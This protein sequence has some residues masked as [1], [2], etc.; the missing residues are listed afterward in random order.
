MEIP[1]R[2]YSWAVGSARRAQ[3]A[4]LVSSSWW[5][6]SAKAPQL[7][8]M[9]ILILQPPR[10]A[11]LHGQGT[12]PREQKVEADGFT[13]TCNSLSVTRHVQN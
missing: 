3:V 6:L 4:S 1:L 2:S 13:E 9:W 8:S 12:V 5:Q 11:Y 10:P 7:Y